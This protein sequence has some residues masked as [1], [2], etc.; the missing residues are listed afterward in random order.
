MRDTGFAT[1]IVGRDNVSDHAGSRA[2]PLV[3]A[4]LSFDSTSHIRSVQVCRD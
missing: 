1:L 3:T 4:Q 2:F